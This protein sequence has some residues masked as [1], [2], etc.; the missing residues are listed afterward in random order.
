MFQNS[1]FMSSQART[2]RCASKSENKNPA[3]KTEQIT[4]KTKTDKNW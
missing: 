3:P 1:L 4:G 2:S